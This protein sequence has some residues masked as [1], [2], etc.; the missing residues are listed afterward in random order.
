MKSSAEQC[1]EVF[2]GRHLLNLQS[3]W[4]KKEKSSK[5]RTTAT[6]GALCMIKITK[7]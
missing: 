3:L 2:R 6:S 5:T 1:R 4:L 7:R